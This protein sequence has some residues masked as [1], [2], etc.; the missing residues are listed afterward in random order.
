MLAAQVEADRCKKRVLDFDRH[1][2]IVQN[3]VGWPAFAGH[4]NLYL[5]A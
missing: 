1:R 5:I 3:P 2:T 4:D